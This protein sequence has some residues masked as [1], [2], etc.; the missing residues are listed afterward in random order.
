[1]PQPVI[2]VPPF[3]NVPAVA[4]VP[5]VLRS[6][7]GAYN[8]LTGAI[9]GVRDAATGE[10][11]ASIDGLL[12][13]GTGQV[14]PI[15]GTLRGVLDGSLNFSALLSGGIAGQAVGTLAG[16]IGSAGTV[17][18]TV[19]SLLSQ[20]SGNLGGLGADTADT[21]VQTEPFQWG[22]FD[23]GGTAVV[24][25]DSVEAFEEAKE[26]RVANYP[27][28]QG[29]FESFNKVEVPQDVR[30]TFKKG[31]TLADRTA[32]LTSLDTALKSL[33]LYDVL[34]PEA[35][36]TSVNIV[37]RDMRRTADK[38]ATL[39]T[40]DVGLQQVRTTAQTT[41]TNSKD[42]SAAGTV[43]AGP[44][45]PISPANVAGGYGQAYALTAALRV[46][47]PKAYFISYPERAP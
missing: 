37:H 2:D 15:L 25:G 11:T 29:A 5:P 35:T 10:F 1:M 23:S 39:L 41:F 42:P 43:N 3:P 22:I 28:E 6:A 18:G 21:T 4:G 17:S 9:T 14:G 36:Y 12:T 27:L 24:T 47:D 13:M 38:G 8:A 40:V 34:T 30:L 20:V 16:V 26:Y 19:T 46:V 7:V 31:G 33:E 45:Q 44:V 32:F